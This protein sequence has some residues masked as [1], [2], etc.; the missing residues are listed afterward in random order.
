MERL[1]ALLAITTGIHQGPGDWLI[2]PQ[3]AFNVELWSFA[4]G[5]KQLLNNQFSYLISVA[6]TIM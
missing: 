3:M 2:L 6:I 1:F 4:G 5:M